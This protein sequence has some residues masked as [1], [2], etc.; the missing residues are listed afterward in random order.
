MT[1]EQVRRGPTSI[2]IMLVCLAVYGVADI[3]TK[4]WAME[5]L[6]RPRSGEQPPVC[7]PDE[8][9]RMAYHRIPLPSQPLIPCCGV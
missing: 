6:S 1:A 9:G 4:D 2:A 8:N 3:A 5:T 7:Q